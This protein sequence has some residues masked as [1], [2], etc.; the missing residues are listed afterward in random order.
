M[1]LICSIT[2]I[3]I[4]Y[5]KRHSGFLYNNQQ[6]ELDTIKVPFPDTTMSPIQDPYPRYDEVNHSGKHPG[7]WNINNFYL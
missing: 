1:A 4:K 5:R 7:H 3:I 6:V 2:V